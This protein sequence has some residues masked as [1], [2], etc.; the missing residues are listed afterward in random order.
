[1]GQPDLMPVSHRKAPEGHLYTPP[2]AGALQRVVKL[3]QLYYPRRTLGECRELLALMYGHESW[4]LLETA[5]ICAE[6]GAC[7]EDETDACVQARR[8]HQVQIAL[9]HCA[10][11][12]H[13]T[14]SNAARIEKDL[15]A[16]EA[17]SISRRHDPYWRR[18]RIDR[19]RYACDVAYARHAIDEIRPT[20][21]DRLPIADDDA[22][23]HTSVRVELLPR[24]LA[25]WIEHQRPRL[26]GLA[27]RI[28]ALR[29]RQRSQC[30]LLNFAFVWG[31]ACV[32]H[33]VDIP[34]ALQIYPLALCAKWYGW[35]AC[36]AGLPHAVAGERRPE[37]PR[38]ARAVALDPTLEHQLALLR[39]Q[40]REDVAT[41]SVPARER[42]MAAGYAVV[43]QHLS[44]AA[45]AQPLRQFV[46]R[47]G[48][49]TAVVRQ[50]IN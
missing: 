17:L 25:I 35:N 33:P 4:E 46:S 7:D 50:A 28:A 45:A 49:G 30:D 32:S 5:A 39:A 10:G 24:A 34:D 11:V 6:P 14:A 27:G 1:M 26:D 2:S 37:S 20:A 44:D 22:S 8:E 16:A 19:G 12:T 29:V 15:A 41:L 40:P 43:R 21:R 42:Q 48:W 18:Q 31:E 36:G 47:P 13:A 3:L 9:T 38:S 23:L